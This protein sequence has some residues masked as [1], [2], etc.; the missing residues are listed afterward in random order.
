MSDV[1]PEDTPVDNPVDNPP[2]DDTVPKKAYEE[3]KNDMLKFKADARKR[4]Q[5][6]EAVNRKIKEL[7]L[8]GHRAKEDY[9]AMY[10]D[11][12]GRAKDFEGKYKDMKDA[13]VN[14]TK[15][16][17]VSSELVSLGLN[18]AA[19]RAAE[20][21]IEFDDIEVEYTSQGRINVL[22]AKEF[23][24]KFKSLHPY[25]FVKG[26]NPGVNTQTPQVIAPGKVTMDQV[27]ELEKQFYKTR[28]P[29]A[30]QKYEKALLAMKGVA[31]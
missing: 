8:A 14:S 3:V 5:E 22:N 17:A 18:Q 26:G 31:T 20:R 13:V 19:L 28:T 25:M 7:E 24:E 23:C 11:A 15:W 9:K 4:E 10:E 30:K 21:L 12:E 2:A 27:L 1:K 16:S 6:L 29:E